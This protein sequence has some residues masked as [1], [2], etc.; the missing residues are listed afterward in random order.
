MTSPE[1]YQVQL[2]QSQSAIAPQTQ[3]RSAIVTATVDIITSTSAT[4]YAKEASAYTDNATAVA[5]DN[6][7]I[8]SSSPLFPSSFLSGSKTI[9][10]V[11]TVVEQTKPK[12]VVAEPSSKGIPVVSLPSSATALGLETKNVQ[13]A[14]PAIS[15]SSTSSIEST[16]SKEKLEA[17]IEE[18]ELGRE[19]FRTKTEKIRIE[20]VEVEQGKKDQDNEIL[21]VETEKPE[22][23]IKEINEVKQK[24]EKEK[25]NE[26]E[27]EGDNRKI[28]EVKAEV[29]TMTR[30]QALEFVAAKQKH[31]SWQE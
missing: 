20:K 21:G 26:K 27:V 31:Q 14:A 22:S 30:K 4:L 13:V 3:S 19:G 6:T 18:V 24:S 25:E 5:L 28:V 7:A 15:T 8:V 9:G 11:S 2:Q 12:A 1:Q 10:G 16:L 23:G 17:E 29:R